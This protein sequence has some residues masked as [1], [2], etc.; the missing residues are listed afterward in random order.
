MLFAAVSGMFVITRGVMMPEK[1][2]QT[3]WP[4][5]LYVLSGLCLIAVAILGALG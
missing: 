2:N 3:T 1:A 4:A 5:L